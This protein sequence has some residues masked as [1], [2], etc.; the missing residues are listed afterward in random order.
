MC[1]LSRVVNTEGIIWDAEGSTPCRI[2]SEERTS[3]MF[4]GDGLGL[5]ST[6]TSPNP[7][8]HLLGLQKHYSLL[9]LATKE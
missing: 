2:R 4:I 7:N 8:Q 6:F 9:R 5:I 3:R 1:T